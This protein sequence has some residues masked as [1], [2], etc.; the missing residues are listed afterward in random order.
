MKNFAFTV[1]LLFLSHPFAT[2][3]IVP[4]WLLLLAISCTSYSS[5]H[6]NEAAFPSA[7]GGLLHCKNVNYQQSTWLDLWTATGISLFLVA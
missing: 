3:P 7:T 1:S 6:S 2:P 4:H 5:V